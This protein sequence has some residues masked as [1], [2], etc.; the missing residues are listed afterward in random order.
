V[1]LALPLV[2]V[3]G[4]AALVY[5]TVW[6]RELRLVF[7]VSTAASAAVVAVFM[8]GLG[9]GGYL[10]GSR[11][12]T[13]A[14]PLKMYGLLETGVAVSAA[15]TPFL[16]KVVAE[17]YVHAGVSPFF[18]DTGSTLARL[19]LASVVLAVPT[20]LM[21]GTL[22]AIARW[23][24][25][26][27][28]LGRGHT[29]ALYAV[30]TLGAVAGVAVATFYMLERLG[31]RQTLWWVALLNT[32]AGVLAILAGRRS[33]IEAAP[34]QRVPG[35][36]TPVAA[37]A[38]AVGFAY[39][40]ME[41]V[42]Y[43]MLAP[44]L[45]GSTYTFG[46]I[47][48]VALFGIGAGAA[49]YAVIGTRCATWT[50]FAATCGLEAVAFLV[51]YALGDRVAVLALLLRALGA[52]GFAG[53]A[54]GWTAVAALVVLPASLIAGYQLPLLIALAGEGNDRVGEDVGGVYAANTVGAIV[55]S[56]AGGFGALPLIGATGVWVACAAFLAA[57]A[58]GVGVVSFW[59]RHALRPASVAA[60]A[61]IAVVALG[62][63]TGP[64][65]F[66][67]QS[68]I[69]AGRLDVPA[70]RAELENVMRYQR[71]N[72]VWQRDG[73]EAAVALGGAHGL[74]FLVSGKS[75]GHVRFD[76]GTQVMSGLLAAMLH[77]APHRSL[78]IG[79]GTG[80]TAG[81]LG[82]VP[83]ME[84]VDVIELEPAILDVARACAD[85]NAGCMSNPKVSITIADGREGVALRD[86]TYDI[87]FSEPSNPY[88]AGV[89]GLF[90]VEHYRNVSRRLAPGGL[91][92][93]WAPAYEVR[94]RTVMGVYASLHAVFPHVETWRTQ[95]GDLL[96]I[97]SETGLVHDAGALKN[98]MAEEP[99]RSALLDVWRVIDL[100]GLLARY[101]AGPST[102]AYLANRPGI[103][104]SS[105][106]W[107]AVEFG[108]ATTVGESPEF[109]ELEL[110]RTARMLGDAEPRLVSTV[111]LDWHMV[112]RR[113]VFAPVVD[114]WNPDSD[115]YS[116]DNAHRAAAA[117]RYLAGDYAG[118]WQEWAEAG[119]EPSD[120]I[121]ASMVADL[122]ADRGDETAIAVIDRL[123]WW[124]R[125]DA[126]FAMARLRLAQHRYGDCARHLA[127][128]FKHCRKEVWAFRYRVADGLGMAEQAAAADPTSHGVSDLYAA[129]GQ[130]LAAR[131]FDQRRLLARVSIA[132]A[133]EGGAGPVTASAISGL[134]PYVPW[135]ASLLELRKDA[136]AAVGDPKYELA[137]AELAE[138]RDM[139]GGSAE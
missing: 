137:A 114:G 94:G 78:V 123:R 77:P 107:N 66:W 51:P 69:G 97:C 44:L 41:L 65:A 10:L 89:S 48:A 63:A 47:L 31:N 16:V 130:P 18:G 138:Y 127:E 99:F 70:T 111:P 92:V 38:A 59:R 105:D 2:A 98:R 19:V 24:E 61:V 30:N 80:S 53:L 56:V 12:D 82:R 67:R 113:R 86:E 128:A 5:Q 133:V 46:L 76:A 132:R 75:D 62:S 131:M 25:S 117:Q 100:E 58:G 45:G 83:S 36:L 14:S 1:L 120:P 93:Q 32:G 40:L 4:F 73:I 72:I 42:W 112:E 22:P 60:V 90:T 124:S 3:S 104:P 136:Y 115:D 88:R 55:G 95:V 13:C 20:L 11:A 28:D 26:D 8:G 54:L 57:T 121:E 39:F 6:M 27:G 29:A 15:I 34:K 134:E 119:G 122:L 37:A 91:F 79:L 84:R 52:A 50:A 35:R 116:P 17:S 125:A 85:V 64:T 106:D 109:G 96:L 129:L 49:V 87:I 74:E 102:A 9:A 68:P 7:G 43:R 135:N 103:V 139:V 110:V 126:E 108:F 23:V 118:A 101:L 71:A 33:S 21:G 81:W